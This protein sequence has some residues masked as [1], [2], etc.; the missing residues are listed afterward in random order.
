MSP[1]RSPI[2]SLPEM[3]PARRYFGSF[4]KD[5]SGCLFITANVI[6]G[7]IPIEQFVTSLALET[8]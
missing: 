8:D 2:H 6:S 3:P 1:V 5:I 7:G 4:A